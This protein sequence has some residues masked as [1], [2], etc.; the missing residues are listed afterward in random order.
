[1]V[2]YLSCIEGYGRHLLHNLTEQL[3]LYCKISFVK[4]KGVEPRGATEKQWIEGACLEV[5]GNIFSKGGGDDG[6]LHYTF[7]LNI[8]TIEI[9]ISILGSQKQHYFI[10]LQ[11][12]ELI[13]YFLKYHNKRYSK[14]NEY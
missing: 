12:F 11:H 6:S 2:N 4:R 13:F 9:D 5:E 10:C 7:S 8:Y 14:I 3:F 1:M